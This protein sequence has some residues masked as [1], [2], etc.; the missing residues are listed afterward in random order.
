MGRHPQSRSDAIEPSS[1]DDEDINDKDIGSENINTEDINSDNPGDENSDATNTNSENSDGEGIA[2]ESIDGETINGIYS[3]QYLLQHNSH[4]ATL[5]TE[6]MGETWST[7]IEEFSQL[8]QLVN[9]TQFCGSWWQ[10]KRQIKQDWVNA[11]HEQTGIVVNLNSL[12]DVQAVSIQ[13]NQRQL[14]NLLHIIT[15]YARLKINSSTDTVQRFAHRSVPRTCIFAN[16]T[17]SERSLKNLSDDLSD[18]SSSDSIASLT[19]KLIQSVADVINRDPDV[20]GRLQVIVLEDDRSSLAQQLYAAADLSEHLTYTSQDLN[21]D[22]LKFALNGVIPIGTPSSLVLELRQAIGVGNIFLFGS[23]ATN[24]N[25]SASKDPKY[26]PY[27]YYST[28]VELRQAIDL[29]AS[30]Y[31]FYKDSNTFDPLV[32][33]LVSDDPH[34]VLA[35]YQ[36]YLNCQARVSQ[37]YQ[38][39]KNWTRMAILTA[40]HADQFCV[41]RTV[42]AS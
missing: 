34:R 29:I 18:D 27:D 32:E 1:L 14:L 35:D 9:H 7:D 8:K 20:Q 15:L 39:Q 10:T 6:W 37:I 22:P 36:S 42:P 13:E 38:D 2:S 41:D 24:A 11:I 12:F 17:C 40:A 33:W 5:L 25:P 23:D 26:D 21:I 30:D 31:F 28:N 19:S 16:S 4:L 3:R